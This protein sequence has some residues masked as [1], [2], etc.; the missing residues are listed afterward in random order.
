MQSNAKDLTSKDFNWAEKLTKNP[1]D[2][3]RT[4]TVSIYAIIQAVFCLFINTNYITYKYNT[5]TNILN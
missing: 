2:E 1:L 5:N 4:A 3:M